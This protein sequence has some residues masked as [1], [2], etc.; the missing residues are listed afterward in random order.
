MLKFFNEE[1]LADLT[2][3][4]GVDKTNGVI[5]FILIFLLPVFYFQIDAA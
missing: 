4:E 1:Q 3:R 5:F 2:S